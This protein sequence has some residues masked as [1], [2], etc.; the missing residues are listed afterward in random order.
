MCDPRKNR[1]IRALTN[2]TK[3]PITL[4][5]DSGFLFRS[6]LIGNPRIWEVE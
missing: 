2:S 3:H 5:H 1:E 4:D 6:A